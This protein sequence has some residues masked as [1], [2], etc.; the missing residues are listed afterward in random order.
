MSKI[1]I[2]GG[3]LSSR[4]AAKAQKNSARTQREIQSY[5]AARERRRL[6]NA[7]R[8]NRAELMT[9]G[10]ASGAMTGSGV[11]AGIANQGTQLGA[12]L[13][14]LNTMNNFN[15]QMSIFSQDAASARQQG[16][17]FQMLGNVFEQGKKLIPTGG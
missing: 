16:N 6:V 2:V 3:F 5:N 12:N 8:R 7:A 13:G 14:H 9:S 4:K 15:N 11:Q 10:Q 17:M 1:A